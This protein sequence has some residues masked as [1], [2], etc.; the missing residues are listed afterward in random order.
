MSL[1]RIK[2]IKMYASTMRTKRDNPTRMFKS[3]IAARAACYGPVLVGPCSG[4]SVLK[5][6]KWLCDGSGWNGN[7]GCWNGNG[8]AVLVAL[9]LLRR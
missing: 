6:V 8:A 2:L 1:N 9:E 3:K 7:G 4:S 5:P